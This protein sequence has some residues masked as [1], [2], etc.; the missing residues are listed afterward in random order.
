MDPYSNYD[1]NSSDN[2]DV[3]AMKLVNAIFDPI[4]ALNTL[5]KL[6]EDEQ[7]KAKSLIARAPRRYLHRNRVGAGEHLWQD[8]F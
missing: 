2:F 6:E 7:N 5:E 1:E 3:G 8:Y 4:A